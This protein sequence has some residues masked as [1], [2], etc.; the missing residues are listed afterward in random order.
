[1]ED[2]MKMCM[3]GSPVQYL[4]VFN[5]L[6]NYDYYQEFLNL[7][8]KKYSVQRLKSSLFKALM[9]VEKGELH[10]QEIRNMAKEIRRKYFQ[11]ESVVMLSE[12]YIYDT[13]QELEEFF[14]T[15][16]NQLLYEK[17]VKPKE[18]EV[19]NRMSFSDLE[20]LFLIK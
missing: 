17:E 19:T 11:Q 20:H 9:E 1:M 14:V 15:I 5:V 12:R 18:E 7:A 10:R 8:K 4:F 6:S 16:C 3:K 13:S 2:R